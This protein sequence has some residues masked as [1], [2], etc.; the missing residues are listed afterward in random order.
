MH[1]IEYK[2]TEQDLLKFNLYYSANSDLHRKYRRRYRLFVPVAYAVLALLL[3]LLHSF[4]VASIFAAV[5]VGWFFLS[6]MWMRR[7][8][9]KQYEKQI[10]ETIG[11][12]LRDPITLELQPDGICSSSYIGESKYRYSAVDRIEENDGYTYIFIGKG[13]ALILPHDRIPKDAGRSLVAEI[14]R[15]K[16]EAIQASDSKPASSSGSSGTPAAQP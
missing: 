1:R 16:Q 7:R 14:A 13:M 11:D 4:V 3:C 6:P 9:R 5:G 2:L 12:S 15:R 8:Y 10:R